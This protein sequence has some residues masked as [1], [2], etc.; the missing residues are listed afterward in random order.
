LGWIPTLATIGVVT[1]ALA[2][3][4]WQINRAAQKRQLQILLERSSALEP[5][6]IAASPM[7]RE[8]LRLRR[9][10]AHGMFDPTR[11]I[12]LDSRVYR[13][14]VGYEVVMPLRI[15]DGDVF[16]LVNRGWIKADPDRNRLPQVV[17]DPN[18]VMVSGIAIEPSDRV[19]ELSDRGYEG[20]VWQHL[21]LKRYEERFKLRLQ[22]ILLLQENSVSD[23]LVRDWPRP[24]VGIERHQGYAFQ[25]FSLAI[26]T[27]ILYGVFHVRKSRRR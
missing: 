10:Q 13:G 9:V 2:L 24:D 5:L 25:W 27:L 14:N 21:R 3:G 16:V 11:V 7:R 8:E 17:T 23:G 19:Y 1:F 6:Q 15:G 4:C 12:F 22:P 20:N 26:A 18:P